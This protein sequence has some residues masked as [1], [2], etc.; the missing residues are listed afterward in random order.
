MTANRAR[1][2]TS[3]PTAPACAAGPPRRRNRR[4]PAGLDAVTQ[5]KLPSPDFAGA[6]GH[7]VSVHLH[8]HVALDRKST[9]LN[10]SHVKISY[11]VFCLKKK[12]NIAFT[13]HM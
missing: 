8:R 9:R 4:R 5:F 7:P 10:S 3:R 6:T 11:A 2:S 12:I 13:Y 1:F